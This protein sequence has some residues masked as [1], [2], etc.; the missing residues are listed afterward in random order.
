MR[1]AL[2]QERVS[3]ARV[4]R[5]KLEE[6]TSSASSLAC[7]RLVQPTTA[8]NGNQEA[9][10]PSGGFASTRSSADMLADC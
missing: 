1:L 4:N 9:V 3:W 10:S 7:C 6:P 2:A 8:G 5:G